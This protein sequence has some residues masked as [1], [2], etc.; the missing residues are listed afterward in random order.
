MEQVISAAASNPVGH[1]IT[2]DHLMRQT[3]LIDSSK[4]EVLP[5]HIIG[6]GAIGSFA[7]QALAKM[8]F[9]EFHLYDMDKVSVENMNCQSFG[10]G[11]IGEPKTVAL[12]MQL[13]D[14]LFA[15]NCPDKKPKVNIHG[16]ITKDNLPAFTG[17]VILSVDS[18]PVRQMLAKHIRKHCLNVK[19]IIDPRM[20]AEYY[21]QQAFDFESFSDEKTFKNY[22]ASYPKTEDV[23]E[24]KCTAKSTVYT[25]MLTA[26]LIAK[27]IKN[28][29]MG[30]PYPKHIDWDISGVGEPVIISSQIL[31]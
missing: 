5:V 16:E 1:V 14:F 2:R 24:A 23:V 8:G 11:H 13:A 20:G 27:T 28:W 6:C 9:L 15:E 3:S 26:G 12:T 18:L 25:A 7:A 19:F 29:L 4:M 30:Q 22:L 31:Q 17:I 10:R 21:F